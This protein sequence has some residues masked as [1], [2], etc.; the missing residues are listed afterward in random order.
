MH[1]HHDLGP[2]EIAIALHHGV[3]VP[4]FEGLLRKQRGVDAAVHHPGAA[5]SRHAPD[6]ITAQRVA[7]MDAD[8]HDI[9]GSDALRLDLL[10]RLVYQDRIARDFG[11][12]AASTKSQRGV[13]TAV[14]KEL[15]L[16]FTR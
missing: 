15:S 12:A 7:G 3:R 9:S 11:V 4:A 1:V 2:G 14:P 10:Q 13:I 6:L 5:R 8:A 16:G